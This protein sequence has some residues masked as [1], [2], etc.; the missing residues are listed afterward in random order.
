MFLNSNMLRHGVSVRSSTKMR[1]LYTREEVAERKKQ[2]CGCACVCVVARVSQRV[3]TT[4]TFSLST[5]Y[6]G[7]DGSNTLWHRVRVCFV[8]LC[9]GCVVACT[10]SIRC[11]SSSTAPPM[12]QEQRLLEAVDTERRNT[13]E[14]LR[15]LAM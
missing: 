5:T 1:T 12:T 6:A 4:H 10:Q 13:E 14:L 3:H 9:G 11:T 2:V 15:L 7:A 8:C